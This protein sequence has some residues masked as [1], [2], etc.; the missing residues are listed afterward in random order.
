MHLDRR[1]RSRVGKELHDEEHHN[2]YPSSDTIKM[3]KSSK[4][5][6]VGGKESIQVLVGK[7][8]GTKYLGRL[9]RTCEGNIKKDLTEI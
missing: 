7:R 5:D 9:R 3:M 4:E 2:F 6:D 1:E 8:V